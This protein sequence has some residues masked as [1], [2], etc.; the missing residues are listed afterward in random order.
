[1]AFVLERGA[2]SSC[3]GT[4][5]QYSA[6][7]ILVAVFHIQAPSIYLVIQDIQ[8]GTIKL[9]WSRLYDYPLHLILETTHPPKR[10]IPYSIKLCHILFASEWDLRPWSFVQMELPDI[11]HLPFLLTSA[12]KKVVLIKGIFPKTDLTFP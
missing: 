1:M 6:C 3:V 11:F 2:I 4:E 12:A 5:V 10:E 9:E 8:H 7:A